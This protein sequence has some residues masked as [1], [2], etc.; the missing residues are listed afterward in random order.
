MSFW[1]GVALI[2]GGHCGAKGGFGAGR[3][4]G[5]VMENRVIFE[6][7]WKSGQ[8]KPGQKN[9]T[10]VFVILSGRTNGAC[11]CSLR[12]ARAPGRIGS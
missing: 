5:P 10:W 1:F 8:K 11:S 4:G 9:E 6:L 7:V 3:D 12:R 2:R